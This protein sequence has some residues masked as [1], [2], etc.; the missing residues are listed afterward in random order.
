MKNI[1]LLFLLVIFAASCNKNISKKDTKED[2]LTNYVNPFI[3]TGGHGHTY[4]GA[5]VPFGM[6]QV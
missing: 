3:G 5:T 4:P 6:L 1:F 2:F